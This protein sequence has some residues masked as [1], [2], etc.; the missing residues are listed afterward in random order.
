MAPDRESLVKPMTTEAVRAALGADTWEKARTY[1][2]QGR[3]KILSAQTGETLATLKADVQGTRPRPYSVVVHFRPSAVHPGGFAIKGSCSCPVS[4]NCKHVGALL[5]AYSRMGASPQGLGED[6]RAWL[7]EVDE[8]ASRAEGAYAA[9]V[10]ERLTYVLCVEGAPARLLACLKVTRLDRKGAP[11]ALVRDYDPHAMVQ[12]APAK[13]LRRS[14]LSI[15]PQL[16]R[17]VWGP[18]RTGYPVRSAQLLSAIL[19]TG[20]ARLDAL[21]GV[22]LRPG[23]PVCAGISWEVGDNGAQTPQ[24]HADGRRLRVLPVH[25]PVCVDPQEGLVSPLRTALPDDVAYALACAPP[26]SPEETEQLC[27]EL[28][29][30]FPGA[31]T[32]LPRP[33]ALTVRDLRPPIKGLA[34][35]CMRPFRLRLP[36]WDPDRRE[37]TDARQV[38]VLEPGYDYGGLVFWGDDGRTEACFSNPDATGGGGVVRVRRRP[39]EERELRARLSAFGLRPLGAADGLVVAP[40]QE[41]LLAPNG[42]AG[43]KDYVAFLTQAAPVLEAEGWM[44]LQDDGFPLRLARLDDADWSLAPA[45][46]SEPEGEEAARLGLSVTVDG[47]LQ[48]ILPGLLALLARLPGDADAAREALDGLAGE[49]ASPVLIELD[50]GRTLALPSGR[51]VRVLGAL[52]DVWGSRPHEEALRLANWNATALRDFAER[53][54]GEDGPR[55][56]AL[57][58]LRLVAAELDGRG[59]GGGASPPKSFAA[60]LRPY[61]HEGVEWLQMLGRLGFGALLADDMGLG[62]TVQTLAHI[63]IEKAAGRLSSP[64]LIVAPKSVLPNWAA[65][66]ARH[67]PDLACAVL[68]GSGRERLV[69]NLGDLDL[70]IT[71]YP[72]LVRDREV[73]LDREWGMVV[74][75]EAQMIRNPETAVARAA[76]GLR[77]PHRVALSGTPVENHL[78]DVWSLMHFLNPGLLGDF[79]GFRQGFRVPIEKRG[80]VRTQERLNRRLAPF[81]LR[82]TKDEVAADLPARTDILQRVDLLPAQRDIYEGVR[83]VMETKVR[84]ALDEKGL[85]RASILVLDALLKLRQA[86]CDPRLVKGLKS[87]GAKPPPSAKLERLMELLQ[88]LQDEGRRVLVF[89]QFVEMLE[90][91]REACEAR[92]WRVAWLTGG[93]EDRATPVMDFQEGRRSIF[94]ISLKAGGVGL[95]LTAADTVILFDPWWNPAAEAQAVDRAHRIGQTQP[96]FVHRLIAADTVEEKVL[97]LQETKRGLARALM[98]GEPAGLAGLSEGELLALFA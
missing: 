38:A 95:N 79:K 84:K 48:D 36:G 68:S 49:G 9:S 6:L 78:G 76:F 31:G 25:P 92:D 70:V 26:V 22:H 3:V 88:G 30:R 24:F 34:R 73:L 75:D 29:R 52:I 60:R 86:A 97:A 62:K 85:S 65:E 81:M 45:R 23:E 46:L 91:I 50:D 63:A 10:R 40:S 96:V 94:L 7:E 41:H 17:Q 20:R 44:I 90:L 12:T 39:G 64:V 72:L 56:E 59:R 11:G 53:A 42:E 37:Y 28:E 55:W 16:G 57:D 58:R 51:A 21:D 33:R 18:G 1:L 32:T 35:L 2:N 93:T 77:T 71:S 87:A 27:A 19:A 69:G 14:D 54:G 15:L 8:A 98:A 82:R 5:L 74:L 43:P 83:L 61:Q 13:F 80:D 67:A 4:W 47:E 66:A 89:S